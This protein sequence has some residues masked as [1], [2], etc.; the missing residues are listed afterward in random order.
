MRLVAPRPTY[1]ENTDWIQP[2]LSSRQKKFS[3]RETQSSV[4]LNRCCGREQFGK[5]CLISTVQLVPCVVNMELV[6]FSFH[7]LTLC[8]FLH[9]KGIGY[10]PH[11]V[12]TVPRPA[13][14]S[15]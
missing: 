14:Q 1:S 10:N 13:A 12:G 3:K 7:P 9:Y 2:P 5:N 4:G 11:R 15:N 6:I 8:K